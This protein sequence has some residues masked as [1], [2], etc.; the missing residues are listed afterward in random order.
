MK[1]TLLLLLLTT[2]FG[3]HSYAQ[4][5][6]EEGYFIDTTGLRVNCFIKNVD[7]LKNPDQFEYRSSWNAKEVEI[8]SIENVAE[9]G[10]N[11]KSR[12]I[13][14]T[15]NIDQSGTNLYS[16][17]EERNPRYKSETVF[18][19]VLVAGNANLY[20]HKGAKV[21]FF[22][23]VGE[24]D[25]EPLVYKNYRIITE[26][27]QSKVKEN[28]RYK[29]QLSHSLVCPDFKD[30]EILGLKYREKELVNLFMK[31][32]AC[33]DNEGVVESE[34]LSETV[35]G[36][37]FNLYIRPRVNLSSLRVKN[38][39]STGTANFGGEVSLGL[40]IEAEFVLP[41][42]NRQW[43]VIVEPYYQR[44]QSEGNFFGNGAKIDYKS[45]GIPVGVRRYFQSSDR[46]SNMFVNF[47]YVLDISFDDSAIVFD[48]GGGLEIQSKGNLV[49]GLGGQSGRFVGELRYGVQ[50]GVLFGSLLNKSN[51]STISLIL[52][53]KLL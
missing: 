11:R 22:Y 9:F 21:S 31:Y 47:S 17:S 37:L 51:L 52:G 24:G 3:L 40:G 15:V 41:F 32:N 30:K 53:Y 33:G 25:I 6:F 19:K 18:L 16:L 46:N 10:I 44:F 20:V 14:R 12:Y 4:A 8:A 34:M 29:Q 23:S 13:R 7:W 48:R 5:M 2:F 42:N 27:N 39:S 28:N 38:D 43:S 26:E 35:K 1:K 49:F 36:N 45:I 50:R